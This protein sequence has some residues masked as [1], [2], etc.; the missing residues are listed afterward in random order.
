MTHCEGNESIIILLL[1]RLLL[2][3]NINKLLPA[4]LISI[5]SSLRISRKFQET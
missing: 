1:D 5:I 2:I 3:V 4:C